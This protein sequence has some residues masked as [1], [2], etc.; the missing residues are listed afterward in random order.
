MVSL[1]FVSFPLLKPFR[2]RTT[3][4][5]RPQHKFIEFH[6]SL[7]CHY[8]QRHLPLVCISSSEIRYLPT[9]RTLFSR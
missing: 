4:A 1:Y 8:F 6:F 9:L 7:L 5:S 2:A 3:K